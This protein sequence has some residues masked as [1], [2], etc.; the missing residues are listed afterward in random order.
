MMLSVVYR[1]SEDGFYPS[2]VPSFLSGDVEFE[3]ARSIPIYGVEVACCSIGVFRDVV[4]V[5]QN[6]FTGIP[7]PSRSSRVKLRSPILYWM[8]EDVVVVYP[9]SVSSYTLSG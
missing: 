2:S 1:M 8:S 6:W 9:S 3:A 4:Q 7:N 5:V